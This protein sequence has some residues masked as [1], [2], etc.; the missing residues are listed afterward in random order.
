[1]NLGKEVKEE[2]GPFGLCLGV[3]QGLGKVG[4][5]TGPQLK[6]LRDVLELGHMNN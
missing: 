1:M 4:P 2:A 3:G 6:G 5:A